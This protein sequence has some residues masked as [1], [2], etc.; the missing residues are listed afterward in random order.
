MIRI[1]ISIIVIVISVVRTARAGVRC[2]PCETCSKK[3][4]RGWLTG[5]WLSPYETRKSPSLPGGSPPSAAGLRWIVK[6]A[7]QAIILSYYC[8]IILLYDSIITMYYYTIILY[9]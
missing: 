2:R 1:V 4:D 6:N 5:F 8:I 7:M 3:H 9:Y